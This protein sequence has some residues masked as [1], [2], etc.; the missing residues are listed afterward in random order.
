MLTMGKLEKKKVSI[1]VVKEDGREV[2]RRRGHEGERER[3]WSSCLVR[4]KW[5]FMYFMGSLF[6]SL[7]Y[8]FE[9]CGKLI[10]CL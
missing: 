5:V 1:A 8:P 4:G 9:R 10:K 2:L 6:A 3:H 7:S